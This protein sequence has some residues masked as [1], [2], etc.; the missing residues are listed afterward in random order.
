MS[1]LASRREW[2]RI[3]DLLSLS[4]TSHNLQLSVFS[5]EIQSV[6][7]MPQDRRKRDLLF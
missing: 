5:T 4:R 3:W 6:R 1:K 7:E 2:E